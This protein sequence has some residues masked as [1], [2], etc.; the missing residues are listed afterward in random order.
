[1]CVVSIEARG[2]KGICEYEQNGGALLVEYSEKAKESVDETTNARAVESRSTA[3]KESSQ[4]DAATIRYLKASPPIAARRQLSDNKTDSDNERMK[5]G[6]DGGTDATAPSG[7]LPAA[8]AKQRI[9]V[10]VRIRPVEDHVARYNGD[11]FKIQVA[12]LNN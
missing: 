1:M 11:P 5:E 4:E 2:D 7:T 3:D 9:Q 8:N 6:R 12:Q 10:V